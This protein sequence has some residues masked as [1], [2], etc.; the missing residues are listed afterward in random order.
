MA[1]SR[2]SSKSA[3]SAK[4]QKSVNAPQK[5]NVKKLKTELEE[6]LAAIALDEERLLANLTF[7]PV[8]IGRQLRENHFTVSDFQGVEANRLL[9]G[10]ILELIDDDIT[11][12]LPNLIEKLKYIKHGQRNGIELAGGEERIK[13]LFLSPFSTPGVAMLEDIEPLIEKIRDRNIRT[14]AHKNMIQYSERIMHKEKDA[15]ET[16]GSCIQ[17]LRT[18]FLQG[19]AGYLRGME[20]HIEEMKELVDANRAMK[21]SYLG[22]NTNFPILME[23]LS[24]FQKEFY[25][26]TGGVGMGKSTF[27]TQ[28]A[29]DLAVL[30]P[31]LTVIFFSL[32]L[33]RLDVTAKI[34]AHAAE[35]PIDYIKNPYVARPDFEDKRKQGLQTVA[36][37]SQR[38]LLVDESSG[39]LFLD[40]IKKFVKRT[41]LE[42]GG[43]VA[44]IIDP[45]FKIQIRNQHLMN[46][47]EKCNF[48]SAEL[49][50]L[51]AVEGVTLIATA[52]LPKAISTRRPVK[53]DLEEIMGLLYDPYAVFFLYSD[54]LNNFDTP[55]LEWEWGKEDSFMIPIS[56]ALIAKNKMGSINSRIFFR[57]YE[58]YSRFKEC[59]PQEVENY[60]AM[61]ENLEKFKEQGANQ[62]QK[63]QGRPEEF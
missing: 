55:F 25:L 1:T 23:R 62:P 39:R 63:R 33:N 4:K 48:L 15:Y 8:I 47:S 43:D 41:R 14:E 26:I 2:K 6:Y 10:A 61:I 11:L 40:D 45:I 21:K 36:E 13:N 19:S 44:V 27:A 29:W 52:G 54:Y 34:V 30:N 31:E 22:F 3:K 35:V 24:G 32:D 46:F 57:F 42:R 38:L 5:N 17:D 28:L 20:S 50:S 12:N 7:D 53:D 58:A 51:S 49:K 56:E 18:L 60:S 59:A 37:M 16:I 9:L